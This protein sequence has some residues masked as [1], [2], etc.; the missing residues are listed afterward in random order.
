MREIIVSILIE[1]IEKSELQPVSGS[2]RMS[3]TYL[4]SSRSQVS[5]K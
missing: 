2:N 5:G 1:L 4:L 3:D